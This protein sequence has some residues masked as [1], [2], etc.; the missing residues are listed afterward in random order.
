MPVGGEV[1]KQ[2]VRLFE[3]TAAEQ[4]V[5]CGV[6]R[7]LADA[8]FTGSIHTPFGPDDAKAIRAK[9]AGEEP[10]PR[11]QDVIAAPATKARIAQL[12]A[13]KTRKMKEKST[14]FIDVE[15]AGA[16]GVQ[17]VHVPVKSILEQRLEAFEGDP[18]MQRLVTERWH[19]E[20]A[21]KRAKAPE[22]APA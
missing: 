11:M 6:Q 18:E 4:T 17:V 2:R 7:V 9:I 10:P 12:L 16:S 20:Q 13:E 3:G 5:E 21:Q 19:E 14:G 8:H 15:P 1:T 22:L